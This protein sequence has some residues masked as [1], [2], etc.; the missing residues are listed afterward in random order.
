MGYKIESLISPESIMCLQKLRNSICTLWIDDLGD[1][2]LINGNQ[3]TMGLILR[4]TN[5]S[6]DY[7][8]KDKPEIKEDG[9][10]TTNLKVFQSNTKDIKD[11]IWVNL[12]ESKSIKSLYI[13]TDHL[14]WSNMENSWDLKVDI[15]LKLIFDENY[16]LILMAKHSS[17]GLFEIWISN[18]LNKL[19]KTIIQA[20][21]NEVLEFW[22]VEPS[23]ENFNTVKR[24]EKKIF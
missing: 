16:S 8:I 22:G 15:G 9:E 14:I 7:M 3:Y 6:T 17:V 4:V 21:N 5:K 11:N 1:T 24:I 13:I 12:L 10:E 2:K 19:D 23:I 18:N 20:S